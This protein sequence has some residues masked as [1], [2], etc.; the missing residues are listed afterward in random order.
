MGKPVIRGT[1]ISVSFLLDL[2]SEGWS[3]QQIFENYPQI[4]EKSL[5][6]ALSY[7]SDRI[8]NEELLPLEFGT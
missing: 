5:R 7:S 6:A 2:L 3:H 4:D 1:R 8:K